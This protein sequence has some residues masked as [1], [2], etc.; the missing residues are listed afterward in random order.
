LSERDEDFSAGERRALDLWR[1]PE[2]PAD[3]EARVQARLDG[4]RVAPRAR[5]Q[6]AVAALAVMLV[7]GFFAARMLSEG[8]T[9]F[10]EAQVLPGDG[11]SAV[12]AS[13]IGDG[14]RS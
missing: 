1:A 8:S 14:V 10:G 3:F 7:G 5:R 2:P 13:P 12:E 9:T 11:G 6:V 4:E